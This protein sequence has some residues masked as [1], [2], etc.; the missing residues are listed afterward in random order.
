MPRCEVIFYR[1][2][3][4]STP[5]LDWLAGVGR[6]NRAAL[7]KGHARIA[8]L[9]E[10]GHELRRPA[11]DAVR[12]GLF[13]PRWRVGK[14]NYRVLYFFHGRQVAVV[15]HGLTKQAALPE[16]DIGRA[17]VRKRRFEADPQA[18][19]HVMEVPDAQEDHRCR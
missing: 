3:D 16:E 9:G 4:G 2:T 18:H 14:V 13:E 15:A 1:E 7:S 17:L 5:V 12:E 11:S 8:L 6:R 19:S 10:M